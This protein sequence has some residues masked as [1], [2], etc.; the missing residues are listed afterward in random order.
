MSTNSTSLVPYNSAA[1]AV[2]T[3]ASEQSGSS[4]SAAAKKTTTIAVL[5][6]HSVDAGVTLNIVKY[7]T[8]K[9][10]AFLREVCRNLN[11]K[12]GTDQYYRLAAGIMGWNLPTTTMIS[13]VK[14]NLR[15][16]FIQ[17]NR[18][19]LAVNTSARNELPGTTIE[20]IDNANP[21]EDPGYFNAQVNKY[22]NDPKNRA[23]LMKDFKEQWA[24]FVNKLG[25][26]DN[27]NYMI[28]LLNVLK[29][30]NIVEKPEQI[31]DLLSRAM[32]YSFKPILFETILDQLLTCTNLNDNEKD[33]ILKHLISDFISGN[34]I[35][36][37]E[38]ILRKIPLE[39]VRSIVGDHIIKYH[40]KADVVDCQKNVWK[41]TNSN[42]YF[43]NQPY[44]TNLLLKSKI[45]TPEFLLKTIEEFKLSDFRLQDPKALEGKDTQLKAR[46]EKYNAVY[47]RMKEIAHEAQAEIEAEAKAG[48]PSQS[49]ASSSSSTAVA[50]AVSSASASSSSSAATATHSK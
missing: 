6:L 40:I 11:G 5:T 30:K 45:M 15:F 50:S 20:E 47:E 28:D 24:N 21:G 3:T 29:L 31:S 19:M 42:Y 7:T 39:K 32:A 2:S 4:N 43:E 17:C 36:F 27:D 48:K 35:K 23:N 10:A 14:P 9:E 13:D 34:Y 16:H 37:L 18:N 26:A 41:G 33:S 25:G 38:M 8:P 1:T 49:T 12:L 22:V 44:R 46:N